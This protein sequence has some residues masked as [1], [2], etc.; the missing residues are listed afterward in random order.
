MMFMKYLS[1]HTRL[2]TAVLLF[3]SWN[4]GSSQIKES[5]VLPEGIVFPRLNTAQRNAL[6]A[7]QGQCIY[8][9]QSKAIECYDGTNWLGSATGVSPVISDADGDTQLQVEASPDADE[10]R[11]TVAGTDVMTHDGQTLHLLNTGES[12]F[13]GEN[14]GAAD[15]LSA[16]Q[17][18]FLGYR[19]GEDNVTGSQNVAIG[20]QA[21]RENQSGGINIAIGKEAMAKNLSASNNIAIGHNAGRDISGLT[22][23]NTIIGGFAGFNHTE[24]GQN[25]ILGYEAG[26]SL[27]RGGHNTF[28]GYQAGFRANASGVTGSFPRTFHNVFIGSR[29]G[30]QFK[31]GAFNTLISATGLTEGSNN[32]IMGFQVSGEADR[33][34]MIGQGEDMMT[35]AHDNTM[36]GHRSGKFW[37]NNVPGPTRY[38]TFVGRRSGP[39]QS[40]SFG[41][42]LGSY[43]QEFMRGGGLN[44]VV[45]GN[46]ASAK[47]YNEIYHH[48]LIIESDTTYL[49]NTPNDPLIYGEFDND[50][51]RINGTLSVRDMPVAAS[52]M[53]IRAT[54]SGQLVLS[55]SDARLKYDIKSITNALDKVTQLRGVSFKWNDDPASGEQL[56]LIAQ[57]VKEVVPELVNDV[58]GLYGVDYTE[59]IGLLVEAIKELHQKVAELEKALEK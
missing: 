29:T 43:T 35:P 26:K 4:V 45:I 27:A 31:E 36:I 23:K 20:N 19:A 58:H 22:T 2:L 50:V 38:N 10:I 46:N 21:M 28:L 59:T 41:V 1:P 52:T 13:I 37:G 7:I 47:Y 6:T 48:R 11:V 53:D 40:G 24:G 56:G 39:S 33:N 25:T 8:N 9:T 51:L 49:N 57:E 12:V 16:N 17:N 32:I 30:S 54:A 34:V 3:A 5:E 55:S 44:N 18:T 15:D 42:V 14:A